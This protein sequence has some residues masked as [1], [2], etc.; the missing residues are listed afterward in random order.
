MLHVIRHYFPVRKALLVVSETIL[1]TLIVFATMSAHLWQPDKELHKDLAYASLDV[2]DALWRSFFSAFI[3]AVLSQVT[4]SFNELY[5]FRISHSRYDRAARFLGSAGSAVLLVI[6]AVGAA[7]LL[8]LERGLAFPG[9]PFT[10]AVV[11]LACTMGL[12]FLLLYQWRNLFHALLRR[13][14]FHERVLILG[15]GRLAERMATEILTRPDSGFEIAAMVTRNDHSFERRKV[16]DRRSATA[17]GTGNPWYEAASPGA[18]VE[19][20][21]RLSLRTE[22]SVEESLEETPRGPLGEESLPDLARRLAVDDIVVALEDRRGNL[23]VEELLRCR[24]DGIVVREAEAFFERLTGKIPAEAMRPSYLIYNPGFVQHPL[25]R[26]V[27]RLLDISCALFGLV[28]IWPLMVVTAIAI[29]LDSSGPVFFRQERVGRNGS[30]FTLIKFRSMRADAEK[31][32]GPVWARQD[33]PRVTRVGRFLRRTRIDELPQ[34]LNVLGGSMSMVGPRPERPTFVEELA[35]QVPYYH[36]RHIVKPG[37]TGW[38]QINY[39]YGNTI[40]DALQKLQ[41][42]LFYIKYQS[43]VFDLSILLNTVKIV[44]LRKGT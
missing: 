12:A 40:E 41:Y 9:L 35:A 38:A 36:Q 16:G 8:G 3:V 29:R 6:L 34:L 42:D 22:T 31:T 26:A 37:L 25:A 32:T 14:R 13:T 19:P 10:Q 43:F 4:I 2:R 11:L 44:V 28:L 17:R 18:V 24:L 39:A 7:E 15:S 23:P 1:I 5:D 21:M 30:P 20:G 33:D 27:K